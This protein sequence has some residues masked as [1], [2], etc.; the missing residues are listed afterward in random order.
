MPFE[1]EDSFESGVVIK[2]VGVGGGGNNA[3][4]RMIATNIRG[5]E[6]IVI[7][8]DKQALLQSVPKYNGETGEPILYVEFQTPLGRL[9]P[10]DSEAKKELQSIIEQKLGKSIELHMLVAED[11]QQTN[12]S[13]ITVDQAIRD[14]I[15]MDVVIEED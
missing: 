3:V 9:Y 8:T 4:N 11:H 7:N 13:Q 12:L 15:H 1:L 2:V 14:N 5:I 6:F 10:D